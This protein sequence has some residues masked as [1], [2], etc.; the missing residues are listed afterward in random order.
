[1]QRQI[2]VGPEYFNRSARHRKQSN[3]MAP[4]AANAG[5]RCPASADELRR[6]KQVSGPAFADELRRGKEGASARCD[7]LIRR[8]RTYSPLYV[9]FVRSNITALLP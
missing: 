2:E 1:M 6:G 7:G 3:G 4:M 8:I 5:A 9:A